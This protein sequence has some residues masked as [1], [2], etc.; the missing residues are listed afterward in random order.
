MLSRLGKSL[1][2]VFFCAGPIQAQQVE[3]DPFQWLEKVRSPKALSW[4]KRESNQTFNLLSADPRYQRTYKEIRK[5]LEAKD[6]IPE[7]SILGE[8]VY[9]FW[10]DEKSVRGILRR[11]TLAD[12]RTLDPKWETVL[13]LDDLA[14]QERKNWVWKG[15]NCLP[16]AYDRCLLY[17]S[18]GG[19][20]ATVVREF[21]FR[22]KQF[23]P[24]GFH[25]KEAK[26]GVVWVNE[27]LLLVS[28]DEGKGTLTTSGYPRRVRYWRRGEKFG[29]GSPIFEGKESD[30]GVWPGSSIRPEGSIFYFVRYP[31]FFTNEVF[32]L[33]ADGQAEK[34]EKP[35]DADHLGFFRG[36]A[37]LRLRTH[38]TVRDIP[39]PGGA[40]LA[41]PLNPEPPRSVEILFEPDARNSA[42]EVVATRDRL[43]LQTLRNIQGELT[44]FSPEVPTWSRKT[45]SLPNQGSIGGLDSDPFGERLFVTHEDF[46]SPRT[47]Y[48]LNGVTEDPVP[49]KQLPS[50]F[51]SQGLTV[52]QHEA[53]SRDGTPIPYFLVSQKDLSL[54]GTHPTILYGYGG[55]EISMTPAYS[56]SVG[57]IW[58]ERGGVYAVANIRGGGEFGPSWHQ[59]ALKENRQRAFEDFIAVAED[60]RARGVTSRKHLGIWGGSNGGLLVAAVFTQR[61]DLMNAVLCQVPLADMLRYHKLLAG[62]SWM[63]EYGDPDDPRMREVILKHS[64]YQNLD[65]YRVYPNVFFMTSTADD[66]VHPGHARKMAAKMKSF[67]HPYLYYENTEGGHGAA[68]NL[69]Q[70]AKMSA[71]GY[72]YFMQELGLK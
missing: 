15:Y 25:L 66:R 53:V 23:V 56:G 72:V 43:F 36:F 2:I 8:H 17:L 44:E 48:E 27:D 51:S 61:P 6:R 19:K 40:T 71:L 45:V 1:V 37:I 55:F 35:D 16:P 49:I 69:I 11:T 47:L 64:P 26:S 65:P 34:L 70:R 21:G 38:W 29:Q 50:R 31:T 28:T 52:V 32:L 54:D 10:Q 67:G 7:G 41:V 58:L 46:L 68:A 60:L 14:R 42:G 22:E 59:A 30:M 12:Y 3:N 24:D 9:N 4:V 63:A 20:D 13:D 57:K 33:D 62:A 18:D 39:Y 5:I